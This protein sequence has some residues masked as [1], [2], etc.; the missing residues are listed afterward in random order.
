MD[1]ALQV[2]TENQLKAMQEYADEICIEFMDWYLKGR[3]GKFEMNRVL[4][5]F[6]DERINEAE[7]F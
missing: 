7:P 6:R 2:S 4:E 3:C 1:E 5:N